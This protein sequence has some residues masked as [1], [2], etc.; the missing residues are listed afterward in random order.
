ANCVFRTEV[1]N[2]RVPFVPES[3]GDHINTPADEYL[4]SLTADGE[5]LVFTRKDGGQEDFFISRRVENGWRK[6]RPMEDINTNLSEGAQSLSA[7]GKVL[8]FT[9]CNR[10][11]GEG[12]CDLY[13]SE[14][15]NGRWTKP[16][17][18]GPPIN[19]AA[20][21]SQ[22]SISADGRTLYF[23]WAPNFNSNNRDIR[24]SHRRSD[25]AWTQPRSLGEEINTPYSE[26]SPFIHP[27][28]QTL[29]FMSNGHPGFGSHDL[30]VSRLQPDGQWGTPRNLGFPINTAAAEGAMIISLDGET[31]YFSTDRA[32]PA[33]EGL[34]AFE[35]PDSKGNSD[36]YTFELY[37]EARPL[38]LTYVRAKVYDADTK[39]PLRAQVEFEELTA[40]E[41]HASSVTDRDGEFLVCLQ[42]GKN[43]ALNVSKEGYLFHSENFALVHRDTGKPYVLEIGLQKIPE[44][45]AQNQAKPVPAPKPIVLK[46]V[47]FDTG[48]ADLRE[49]SFAE[50]RRLKKLLVDNPTMRI[51]VS[52]HTDNIGSEEAN[53][54]LSTDR[55]RSVYEFLVREG[56]NEVRLSYKGFGESQS[57][58]TN[59]S[60]EGRQRNR[61]T[62]FMII[63]I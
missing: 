2:T 51:Q 39:K 58:D 56:I 30:F 28:G 44:S 14:V 32:N 35:K 26:Q 23:S 62:E 8:V 19:T 6:G 5:T 18:M 50:L 41:I 40:A 1:G 38:P 57:I 47:F 55:A 45:L 11:D 36:I 15:K 10:R 53:F 25:G 54:Q 16:A 20:W 52:G 29:Y 13:F 27:D 12:S 34:S 9:A 22:P 43:Y 48:S 17:N 59:E 46:N 24:V 63:G 21:E 3:I 60:A 33:A 49:E 7:D 31:A 61:R 4:P 37:P 42:L